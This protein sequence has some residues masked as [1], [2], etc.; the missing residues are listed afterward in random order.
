MNDIRHMSDTENRSFGMF[1]EEAD[2]LLDDAMIERLVAIFYTRVREDADLGPVF[3]EA[4]HDWP[5]HLEHLAAFWSSIMLASGRYKGNP[6]RAH[7]RWRERITPALFTRWLA[8]WN[9]TCT[10]IMPP[11]AALSLQMKAA[12]IADSLQQALDRTLIQPGT[13]P[14]RVN[15]MPAS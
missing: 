4:V 2:V 8:L 6:M 7:M 9:E 15:T 5:E 14:E 13:H 10:E 3:N 11:Q 12:R 1:R